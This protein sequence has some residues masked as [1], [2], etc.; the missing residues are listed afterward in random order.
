MLN[1]V[2]LI[3]TEWAQNSG[4]V[5]ATRGQV[6]AGGKPLKGVPPNTNVDLTRDSRIPLMNLTKSHACKH[7]VLDDKGS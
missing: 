4:N 5:N 3:I 6:C 1:P 7:N 2:N